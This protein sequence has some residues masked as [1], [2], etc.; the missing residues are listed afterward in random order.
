VFVRGGGIGIASGS[1]NAGT[2]TSNGGVGSTNTKGSMLFTPD[3]TDVYFQQT[4][5][6][7]ILKCAQTDT[8]CAPATVVG[9]NQGAMSS[10]ETFGGK[11]YWFNKGRDGFNEGKLFTCDLPACGTIKTVANGLDS[12]GNLVIDASGAYWLTS[13]GALVPDKLQHCPLPTCTGGAQDV[14][15]AAQPGIHDLGSDPAFLYW[16]QGSKI[17]RLAKP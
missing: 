3:G 1:C 12:P 2:C 15:P 6:G 5:T 8:A 11:L 4:S 16:V 17:V 13:S 14:L 9:V 7:F 10:M